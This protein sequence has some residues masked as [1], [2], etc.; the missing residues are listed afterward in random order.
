LVTLRCAAAAAG[1]E[2]ALA[3]DV[4]PVEH[5]ITNLA[6]GTLSITAPPTLTV[7]ELRELVAVRA[8]VAGSVP[9]RR[10]EVIQ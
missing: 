6:G 4:A 2:V 7:G 8:R 10:V 3:E 5:T 1:I 9:R